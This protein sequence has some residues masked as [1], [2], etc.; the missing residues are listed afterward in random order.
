MLKKTAFLLMITLIMDLYL[1]KSFASDPLVNNKLNKSI[2]QFH[3]PGAA[4]AIIQN[5]KTDAYYLGYANL[6]KKT[7]VTQQT[8]FQLGS[9]TELM[10]SLLFAEQIDAAKMQL[11][12]S[13]KIFLPNL[14][15]DDFDD[16]TLASLAT[17]T[18]G[19]PL[20][21][22]SST[23]SSVA[24]NQ[25][26]NN[27]YPDDVVY[28]KWQQSHIGMGL[29]ANAIESVT[30]KKLETL[31]QRD[32]FSRLGM[33]TASLQV[34][35]KNKKNIAQGYNA[36]NIPVVT[37]PQQMLSG[38]W[39]LKASAGD[40]Q[41]FLSAAI[42]MAGTPE[43]ILY[44]MRMT[45]AAFVELPQSKQGM[46][47]QIY[48]LDTNQIPSLPLP[49]KEESVVQAYDIPAKAIYKPNTLLEKASSYQ[50]YSAYI[51]VIP[52]KQSGIVILMNKS[53][54]KDE[55]LKMG[56]QL[57]FESMHLQ[58]AMTTENNI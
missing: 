57:F 9:L 21:P 34:T 44:P 22:P 28:E 38:A 41:K 6:A 1:S 46:G 36:Q 26:L 29:L 7:P 12:N 25:Y 51:A 13:V 11:T 24:M 31:Y 37:P 23:T 17:H 43:S 58:N 2:E 45:Q 8:I 3:V 35:V 15:S 30:H 33:Q 42:G 52:G 39:G 48:A 55:L 49:A 54:P 47:W 27:W 5:G 53:I 10:T 14:S 16:I 56:R 19:L 50:G 32:I 4:V 40:M 18:A 20:N